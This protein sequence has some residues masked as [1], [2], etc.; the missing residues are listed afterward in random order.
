[1]KSFFF[2]VTFLLTFLSLNAQD[3]KVIV[4]N[5]INDPAFFDDA[6]GVSFNL[7]IT[8]AKTYSYRNQPSGTAPRIDAEVVNVPNNFSMSS[9]LNLD[10][11]SF[12]GTRWSTTVSAANFHSEAYF[13]SGACGVNASVRPF[14]LE[15]PGP[16][17]QTVFCPEQKIF[18]ESG[19]E[20]QYSMDGGLNWYDFGKNP[21]SP[22]TPNNFKS[23]RLNVTFNEISDNYSYIGNIKIRGVH[24]NPPPFNI[25]LGYTNILSFT[26]V[27]C[28]PQLDSPPTA[29]NPTCSNYD[30][31]SFTVTF[32]RELDDSVSEKMN[33]QVYKQ[34]EGATTFD[35]YE[36]KVLTKSDFTGSSYTWDP[37]NLPGGIY[38]L[39]WQTKSNNGGFDDIGT[40]PDAY[41][42]SNPFTLTSPP[43]LSVNGSPS[44]VQCLGGNDGS[45]IVTPNGGTPGTPPTS[46]RYQY[47]IDN[48]TTW[49]EETLFDTLS[50]GDYTIL[51]K[52][53]NGCEASS[54]PITVGERFPTIPNVIPVLGTSPTLINGNNG[55]IS[56]SVSGGAGNY[57]NY[58]WTK[59]GNPFTPPSGSTN[60]NIINLYEGVY[61]IIVTDSNGCSS[62][63][64]IFTLT[65]PEP[66]D[67]SINMTP[68][69]V[70][71]S[72][73]KVNLIASATG[74]FL[75][76]GSEYTYA[77]DDGTTGA[78]LT[79]VGI[80]TYQVSVT[81]DG[82][83]TQ[84][85][86]FN[87][88]GPNPIT[89]TLVNKKELSCRDGNDAAIQL[90]IQGGTG[91]YVIT[92]ENTIDPNFSALGNE[93]KNVGFGSYIYRVVDQNGCFATNSSQPIEFT[94]PPL[95][96]IDLGE[97][98]FFCEGQT[99]TISAAIQDPNASYS[100]TSDTGFT[101]TN[102]EINVDQQGTY[103]VTVT[104][105]KGC[106][107]Q[108]SITV[109][110]NI[111]EINA[112]FL[113]AS[114]V[115]TNEKFVVID[116]TYPIPDQ[117]QW[118]MPEEATI[119]TQDQDLIELYFNI[120]GEYDISMIS[121]L[122]DC[123]DTFTQKVLVLQKEITDD[124]NQDSQNQ[125]S[126]NIKEFSVYPNPSD[127]KFF[128]KVALKE[129]KDI[130]I[131]VFSLANN[132]ILDQKKQSG[133]KQYEIP[134]TLQMPSGVYA[135]VLETPYGNHIRK[136]IMK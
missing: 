18:L 88:N 92:W 52:D 85:K 68:D 94:N 134:F 121:K 42:E 16:G 71:C 31:G 53:N 81:D 48:G 124:Q 122:G 100:W 105:G 14:Y 40:N 11:C 46:P 127:G 117:I 133:K 126:G 39:F 108:D 107:A 87:V 32:D 22:I 96:S 99:V 67:I 21:D 73:T 101:N 8:G 106:I 49:Q 118:V 95:F 26:I 119:I 5:T 12:D 114:Q 123:Q 132:T 56:I 29:I 62:D 35:G 98:P 37:K 83:N 120:P 63:I 50:K 24:R 112:E 103:T 23:A 17:D 9:F 84:N 136:V 65:D 58:A 10:T 47:S 111:K 115:F 102:P 116:V 104:S 7:S 72:D 70:D 90:T 45:I 125:Q 30:N 27:N 113:Y 20:W 19:D 13:Y 109:I 131:K 38:K 66:I 89:V 69:T 110:E 130:S 41:D 61:T 80:G 3:R 97:D 91:D 82:G 86:T 43:A 64:E 57:T 15:P 75:N 59:D 55:R 74:G 76:S 1:M 54:T 6:F 135:V 28:S 79:N 51:I 128:V 77:W 129:Q 78:S 4:R 60:T 2:I 93:L 33:L 36:S 25:L 44:P 34:I